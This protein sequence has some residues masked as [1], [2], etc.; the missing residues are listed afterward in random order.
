MTSPPVGHPDDRLL[1]AFN[2]S[3]LDQRKV[4]LISQHLQIC[5]PCQRRLAA[6]SAERRVPL[7]PNPPLANGPRRTARLVWFGG[8]GAAVLG[9]VLGWALGI[10]SGPTK[11]NPAAAKNESLS[12][13]PPT[14]TALDGL[15]PSPAVAEPP[16]VLTPPPV[17]ASEN[18]TASKNQAAAQPAKNAPTPVEHAPTTLA[19]AGS[20]TSIPATTEKTRSEPADPS[21][22]FFNGKDLTGWRGPAQA[23]HVENGSI[24][25]SLSPGQKGA[26]LLSS[27][28]RYTDFDLMFRATL[29]D[30]IG[31]GGVQFRSRI[32]EAD[33]QHVAGPQ[34]AIYGKDAPPEHRTGSLVIEPGD[35]IEKSP[36]LKRVASF[37]E[38]V[39]NH[40]RIRC[41]GKHVLIEV[42][43]IKMVNGEFPSLPDEGVIAWR[44]DATRPPRKVTFNII[45]F[46]DL[47]HLPARGASE[48]PS[49][50]DVE[51][52]K[53]EMKFE[54]AMKKADETLL[55]HFDAELS[56]LKRT[57]HSQDR[58]MRFVVEHEKDA[59]KEKGLVPWS[60]P[61][62]KWL[63]Q[64]GRELHEAQR[65]IG[66]SFDA[67]IERAEKNHNVQRKTA[68]LA[69]AGQVL[70]PREVATW[71]RVDKKGK[72][73]R[74]TFYSDGT[75]A[76][77]EST[78]ETDARFWTPPAD[79]V[80]VLEFPDKEEAANTD[81]QEFF[82]APDGKTLTSRS[83]KGNIQV[84]K[85]AD[86]QESG[87]GS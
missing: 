46:V 64:Y 85:Q 7:S 21:L 87:G 53:A 2:L 65:T 9:M 3:K 14:S 81:Q 23:W 84:W 80:L 10:F 12:V 82:L 70:A 13:P 5:K 52:L 41:Q 68:L 25:G 50:S 59:F 38:P 19:A 32:D 49:L 28:E 16:K 4:T 66:N 79:D 51:L 76:D 40:Y 29:A 55:T 86:D 34:C 43:G 48:R 74:R 54:S 77:G 31:D 22:A 60:R 36:P 61:M 47:T 18:Q 57:T 75:F 71:Q 11:S 35:K 6:L 62:R 69:E 73:L 42:N 24:V 39:E 1:I 83:K 45:K 44:L 26:A 78:G 72:V 8:A 58:E 30:G 17:T 37:V 56:R 33:N 20:S 15:P 27:R 67:A 63:L